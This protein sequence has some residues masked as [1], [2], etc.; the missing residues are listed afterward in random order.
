MSYPPLNLFGVIG[1]FN[2]RYI[3]ALGEFSKAVIAATNAVHP[4]EGLSRASEHLRKKGELRFHVVRGD[5]QMVNA[6]WV[7]SH[8]FMVG[9]PTI[10]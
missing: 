10:I 1:V 9:L 7:K 8:V 5:S 2:K 4:I 6:V 3:G